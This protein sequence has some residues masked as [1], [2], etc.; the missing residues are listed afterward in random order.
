V[1]HHLCGLF[2]LGVVLTEGFAI[3]GAA[4]KADDPANNL[5]FKFSTNFRPGASSIYNQTTTF[6][7]AEKIPCP[8][9]HRPPSFCPV[10]GFS[11]Q[12]R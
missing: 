10:T 8:R 6:H 4:D 12:R 7:G 3:G 9:R 1:T 11:A 5:C 2:R